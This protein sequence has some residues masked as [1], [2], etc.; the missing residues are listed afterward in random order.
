M[1]RSATSRRM[2]RSLTFSCSATCLR[3]SNFGRR[4][5][6]EELLSLMV[7]LTSW[8]SPPRNNPAVAGESRRAP[9][10]SLSYRTGRAATKTRQKDF[11][12]ATRPL[13]RPW[14]STTAQASRNWDRNWDHL[15]VIVRHDMVRGPP[16]TVLRP[17]IRLEPVPASTAELRR[18]VTRRGLC[19][20]KPGAAA[21]YPKRLQVSATRASTTHRGQPTSTVC[22]ARPS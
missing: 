8:S 1:R 20:L 15:T 11:R 3:V 12:V 18:D 17:G 6:P 21:G 9:R 19:S 2:C 16:R 5:G 14:R 4:P 10:S 13:F 7:K 22:V